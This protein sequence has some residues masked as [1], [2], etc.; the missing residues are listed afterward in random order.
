MLQIAQATATVAASGQ[1]FKPHLVRAIENVE[2]RQQRPLGEVAL[3]PVALKPEQVAFIHSALY[4]VTQE[5]TSK[6][7]FRGAPY[8][9]GGKT[10]T[11][12]VIAIK[13][14][15]KYD[16]SKLDER[17]RDHALYM[18]FAPLEQPQIA[19]AMVVENAG[20][21]AE[22]AAPI[23]RRVFDYLL[24]GLLPSEE[25]IAQTQQGQS[26]AP[27]GTQRPASEVPLPGLPAQPA[28]GG[29]VVPAASSAPASAPAVQKVALQ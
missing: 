8:R 22:S 3:P 18:A 26:S 12:Q 1:R 20:F 23:A 21:G 29:A 11:A 13:A 25:D 15:E 6:S 5:G 24:Q 7:S 9:S 4:G 16:A 28:P 10:G 17:H 14:N 2:T 27:I 19:L